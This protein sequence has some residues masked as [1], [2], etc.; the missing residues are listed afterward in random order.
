VRPVA[1]VYTEPVTDGSADFFESARMA[2]GFRT[3]YPAKIVDVDPEP[4]ILP[5][6]LRQVRRLQDLTNPPRGSSGCEDCSNFETIALASQR[7]K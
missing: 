4:Q 7:W 1:L 5:T 3:S 2:E 6:L